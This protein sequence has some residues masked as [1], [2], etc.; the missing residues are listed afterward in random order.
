MG[1]AAALREAA[2]RLTAISATPRL[3]AELLLAHALRIDRNALL[4]R[5]RDLSIP[6]GFESLLQ[7]RLTGEPIAYITGARDFWTISLHVTPDVL[8]PR[9]DSE[10]LIEAALDH[11][12]TRSPARILDLGTG[13]GALLLAA[14]SQWPRAS[15]VG[16]DISPA[17]LAIA[18]GNADRLGLSRRADFRT[19]DWA[20][21]V[22]G[23]FDLILINPPYIARDA[24][25]SG[26]VLHEPEGALFAGA[27]GLDDYRRIAPMLPRL[28]APDGMA[29]I[30]IG[31]DQRIGVTALLA[32]QAFSV[33]V[34]RD[35]AG[36]DRCLVATPA[37]SA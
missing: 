9:P 11:F 19:G 30:E 18:Q 4:L 37:L 10:T 35:L 17:A 8:I 33:A 12:G 16:I 21:G 1:V 24:A 2:E 20:E 32:D 15:G 36:H 5:Q 29:A 22:D 3:D 6:P 7:R 34:R 14:L 31:Y 13:S 23:P 26:D 28:L 27:E 25:L